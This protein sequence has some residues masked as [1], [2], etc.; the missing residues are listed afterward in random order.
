MFLQY[1]Y[2]NKTQKKLCNIS[3]LTNCMIIC[4]LEQG[5]NFPSIS[6]NISN[7]FRP[8]STQATRLN[9]LIL[10]SYSRADIFLFTDPPTIIPRILGHQATRLISST[11]NTQPRRLRFSQSVHIS[12]SINLIGTS[13]AGSRQYAIRLQGNQGL[14]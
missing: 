4:H 3:D 5:V 12:L 7:R 2:Q 1:S 9:L 6:C 10:F 8:K 11:N 13:S 14:M